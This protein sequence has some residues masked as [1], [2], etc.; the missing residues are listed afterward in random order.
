MLFPRDDFDAILDRLL[1]NE[2]LPG[3]VTGH[4][5]RDARPPTLSTFPE[6]GDGP[7]PGLHP[8]LLAALRAVGVAAPYSHQAEAIEH[9]LAGHDV[10]LTTPTASGKTLCF[11]APVLNAI[12]DDPSARALFLFPTKALSADQYANLHGLIER[13][14]VPVRTFTFDGDTPQ[15]A[16]RA[17][18][19]HGQ[20]VITNPD[21]LHAAVL[22]QHTK[23]SKLFENLRYVV[24]DELHTYRG[25]FGSHMAHVLRRL[26]RIAA[27]HGARPQIIA[28]SATIRNPVELAERLTGR[29]FRLVAESG[30][31]QGE[32]HYVAYNPPI[33]NRQLQI[34]AGALMGATEAALGLLKAG[35]PTIVFA[36]S[37]LYVEIILK[38]LREGLAQS[39][40]DPELVQGYRGGYLPLHRRRIEA[41]LR[42]GS[43]RGVVSTNALEVGIDIGSLQAAVIAGFPGSIASFMQQSGR[44]GRR[45]G[46]AL[47]LFVAGSGSLDQYL[48]ANARDSLF[49][50]TSEVARI[51]PRNLFVLTDH[52]KCA[53]YELPF[54]V[55]E[56]FGE[57]EAGET[58]ELLGYLESHQ[59]LHRSGRSYHW[60]ERAFP[61]NHVNLRGIS[62]ENFIVIDVERDKVLAEV[63]FRSAHTQLHLHAIYHVDSHQYQVERLDYDDHKAF[64]RRVKPDYYT[65]A[66]TY[67][68]VAV[69][70]EDGLRP[71]PPFSLA[72]GE[73]VVTRKFIGFK[74]VRFHTHEVIGYGEIH[75]PDLEM[76]TT[77]VWFDVPQAVLASL[78]VGREAALDA[79]NAVAH[80]LRTAAAARLMCAERDLD[81][82]VGDRSDGQSPPPRAEVTGGLFDPTLYLYDA[83]P[84][85]TGLAPD[86]HA[87]FDA[88]AAGARGLL[89]GCRCG[90]PTPES[91]G[92]P[93]CLGPMPAY[94]RP[95]KAAAVAIL[96]RLILATRPLS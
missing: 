41:G 22:P 26:L 66:M 19:D 87:D 54:E 20:I 11:N 36:G 18:R 78:G 92:C 23:W 82:A 5:R 35:V 91:A 3:E 16:R 68:G 88:I 63:D 83:I 93:A 17:V 72:H 60:M 32:H 67:T 30:A 77:A 7:T 80:A 38:Y 47:T 64:V 34:R 24:I 9:A 8:Q 10:V 86:L 45:D 1:K 56:R 39:Q 29:T 14:D 2:L 33:V 74:K 71:M 73:V 61:A 27:F 89:T 90:G 50:G 79:L 81:R 62:E 75:L 65:T 6:R 12:L 13:L 55:G 37:R 46:R 15:D 40:L 96:D 57:L 21:M 95:L 69:I 48:V 49:G 51:N 76:H 52:A 28:C 85:G 94:T 84:G 70:Q 31:P 58:E 44:A 4:A 53:A 59:V 43:V 42:D 25:V